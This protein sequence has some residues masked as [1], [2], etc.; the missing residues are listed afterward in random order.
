MLTF[1]FYWL[2]HQ[3]A[4]YCLQAQFVTP[5]PAI[6]SNTA[7]EVVAGSYRCS[8]DY[9]IFPDKE[10]LLF[11]WQIE[12]PFTYEAYLKAEEPAREFWLESLK[13]QK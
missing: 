2:I 6:P 1:L 3:Y 11:H 12:H 13:I 8:D 10:A 7:L 4:V 5:P 9:L